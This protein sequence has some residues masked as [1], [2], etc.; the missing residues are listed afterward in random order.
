VIA[1]V[2]RSRSSSR[3]VGHVSAGSVGTAAAVRDVAEF[4]AA[5]AA[6]ASPEKTIS[7]CAPMQR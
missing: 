3:D 7:P 4:A 2:M 6:H 1:A 5:S